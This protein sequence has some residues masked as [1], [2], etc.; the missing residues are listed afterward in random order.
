MT[1]RFLR[2]TLALALLAAVLA[3][4]GGSSGDG[5]RADGGTDTGNVTT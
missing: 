4:C 1:K 5:K 2:I 3:G